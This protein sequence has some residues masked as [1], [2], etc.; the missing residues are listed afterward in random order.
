NWKDGVDYLYEK[1][2]EYPLE[3]QNAMVSLNETFHNMIDLAMDDYYSGWVGE[4]KGYDYKFDVPNTVKN[5]SAI[6]P[7]SVAFTTDNQQIYDRRGLPMLEFLISREKYLYAINAYPEKQNQN[8]S[9]S[10]RG[11]AMEMWEMASIHRLLGD[12]NTVLPK[13]M[14]RIFG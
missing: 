4:Y 11:P 5:V 6:H 7:L 8:P 12:N 9:H 14:E 10:L 3:R 2:M 1:V 13:E